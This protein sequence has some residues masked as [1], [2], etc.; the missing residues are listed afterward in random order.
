MN[1][2]IRNL[3]ATLGVALVVAF[4]SDLT[5]DNALDDFRHVWWLLVAS[6]IS[7]TALA[8][9]LPRHVTVAATPRPV[10]AMA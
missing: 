7:V 1:Q 3:G 9:R 8:T 5:P 10:G 6:G 2:A 4:T